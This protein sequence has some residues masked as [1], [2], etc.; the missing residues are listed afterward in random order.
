M[1]KRNS[2]FFTRYSKS[3]WY[4]SSCLCKIPDDKEYCYLCKKDKRGKT[5]EDDKNLHES[6]DW[7]C[8]KCGYR[9]DKSRIECY[10]C[11]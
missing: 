2:K 4:C 9:I 8:H 10:T 11:K 1:L 3:F 7:I 5:I 6:G